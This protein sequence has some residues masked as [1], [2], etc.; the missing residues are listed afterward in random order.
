MIQNLTDSVEIERIRNIAKS[1]MGAHSCCLS[2]DWLKR[3]DIFCIP[4]HNDNQGVH[5]NPAPAERSVRSV[6]PSPW[7]AAEV[8]NAAFPT[9][10]VKLTNPEL[11]M[12]PTAGEEPLATLF[13]TRSYLVFNESMT[14]AVLYSDEFE[15]RL[16]AGLKDFV[17]AYAGNADDFVAEFCDD[18]EE[19]RRLWEDNGRQQIAQFQVRS[20]ELAMS[21]VKIPPKYEE[22]DS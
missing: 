22:S 20:L 9:D 19:E 7:Y 13:V 5:L 2:T 16:I 17:L 12:I 8:E 10:I 14:A 1:L 18:M 21:Q 15:Y 4:E 3:D 6:D 11:H